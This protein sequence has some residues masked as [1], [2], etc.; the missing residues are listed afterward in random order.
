M[1]AA[2]ERMEK[3]HIKH[4]T[5]AF[6]DRLRLRIILFATLSIDLQKQRK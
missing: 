1:Y 2:K 5:R 4:P 6:I 3:R